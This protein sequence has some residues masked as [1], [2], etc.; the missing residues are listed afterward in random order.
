MIQRSMTHKFVKGSIKK[1]KKKS[2]EPVAHA[3]NLSYSEDRERR[4]AI[5][6]QPG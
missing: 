6:S 4:I 5:Q 1:K 2:W 3:C